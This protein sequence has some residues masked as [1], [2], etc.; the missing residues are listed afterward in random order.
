MKT[1]GLSRS[2]T[3]SLTLVSSFWARATNSFP[4]EDMFLLL[5]LTRL[6]KKIVFVLFTNKNT[7]KSNLNTLYHPRDVTRQADLMQ[8]FKTIIQMEKPSN[9]IQRSF[10]PAKLCRSK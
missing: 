1:Y 2:L 7:T 5:L 10:L 6:F 4:L 9:A 8:L 3:V